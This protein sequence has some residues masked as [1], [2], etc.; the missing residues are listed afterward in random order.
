MIALLSAIGGFVTSIV[1]EIM[2]M[3]KDS[4]ARKHELELADR[5]TQVQEKQIVTDAVKAEADSDVAIFTAS[6]ETSRT[7]LSLADKWVATYSAT[8]RPTVTYG[9]FMLFVWVEVHLAHAALSILP[10]GGLPWQIQETAKIVWGD[11][12][13]GLFSFILGY[14]FGGRSFK[15]SKRSS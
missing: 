10:A 8:V 4:A 3:I 9:F 12:Q 11:E 2:G 7:E 13:A 14:W 6:Q 1:P 15:S 5:A